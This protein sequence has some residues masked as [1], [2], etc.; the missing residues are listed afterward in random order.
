[1]IREHAEAFGS[2][3]ITSI[4]EIVRR[5]HAGGRF[6]AAWRTSI[7]YLALRRRHRVRQARVTRSRAGAVSRRRSSASASVEDREAR[8]N[9]VTACS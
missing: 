9:S 6:A 3:T 2:H 4:Y 1:M 7:A 5:R 8:V